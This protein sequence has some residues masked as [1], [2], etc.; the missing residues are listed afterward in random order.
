MQRTVTTSDT[1][2]P[3][4][5]R[6]QDRLADATEAG[7]FGGVQP[8][9]MQ[10][11]LLAAL[12]S[13][14]QRGYHGT[15]TRDIARLAKMSAAGLYTHY[16]S[17]EELLNTIM[18]VTHE[19]ML[20]EMR[21][22]FAEPGTP[23]ERLR[24]LVFA[25]AHFHAT[26]H[27]A[28]RVANYELHSLN[29]EQRAEMVVLRHDMEQVMLAALRLGIESGDFEVTDERLTST[30]ILSLG[31]DIGRWFTA[32]GRLTSDD[33]AHRYSEMVLHMVLGP[34]HAPGRDRKRSS[35]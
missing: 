23:V 28:V 35:A 12:N 19:A 34:T 30:A 13:F 6:R 29:A 16:S 5:R 26:F 2:G 9:T 22:V 17:K 31:I 4:S 21:T 10:R 8:A 20:Q 32:T 15:T 11:L 18:R 33:I 24:R 7:L 3:R 14:S 25:H 1:A 27:T